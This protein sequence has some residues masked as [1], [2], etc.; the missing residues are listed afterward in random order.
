MWNMKHFISL[1]RTLLLLGAFVCAGNTVA[2]SGVAVQEFPLQLGDY[3]TVEYIDLLSQTQSPITACEKSDSRQYIKINFNAKNNLIGFT[4]MGNFHEGLGGIVTDTSMKTIR[5]DFGKTP[6]KLKVLSRSEFS[7]S[8][9]GK[10]LIYRY[11]GNLNQYIARNTIAGKY[12]D[13]KGGLYT[14]TEEGLAKFPDHIFRYEVP[15]D[16]MFGFDQFYEIPQHRDGIKYGFKVVNK[17]LQLFKIVGEFVDEPE[18]NPFVTLTR[19]GDA[20]TIP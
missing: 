14:L 3:L 16:L 19:I 12:K 10:T 13:D 11:V 2:K 4:L 9:E 20:E 7:I 6:A 15:T 18:P 17:E 5:D 8:V 1:L